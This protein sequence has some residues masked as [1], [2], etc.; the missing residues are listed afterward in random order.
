[1]ALGLC[2]NCE[3]ICQA[4]YPRHVCNSGHVCSDPPLLGA[5]STPF[6]PSTLSSSPT[7]LQPLSTH[8][9]LLLATRTHTNFLLRLCILFHEPVACY[10]IP[11]F[12]SVFFLSLLFFP[13]LRSSPRKGDSLCSLSFAPGYNLYAASSRAIPDFNLLLCS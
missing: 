1:M 5:S 10:Y 9:F 4:V 2:S 3:L 13:V 7:L 12:P 6:Y 11:P 8:S